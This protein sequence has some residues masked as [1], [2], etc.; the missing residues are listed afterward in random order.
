MLG[1]V[2]KSMLGTMF[3]IGCRIFGQTVTDCVYIC[4][5]N[6]QTKGKAYINVL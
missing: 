6:M 4:R 5:N 2:L 1:K 3:K